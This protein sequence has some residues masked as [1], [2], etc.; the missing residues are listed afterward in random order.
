MSQSIEEIH[1]SIILWSKGTTSAAW[2]KGL[3]ANELSLDE[4]VKLYADYKDTAKSFDKV[5]NYL[6]VMATSKMEALDESSWEVEGVQ[7]TVTQSA[8]RIT[9]DTK[10]MSEDM[11]SN[12]MDKYSKQGEP[13]K[14]VR[15]KRT[16]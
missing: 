2:L 9:Y 7:V 6:K 16:V 13:F 11:G 12:F 5:A 1:D 14:T 10:R 4:I 3:N 15:Y 8:G